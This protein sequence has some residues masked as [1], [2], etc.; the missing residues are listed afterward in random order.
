MSLYQDEVVVKKYKKRTTQSKCNW[1]GWF[2]QKV[3]EVSSTHT[4]KQIK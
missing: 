4:Q 2:I 1:K 3:N